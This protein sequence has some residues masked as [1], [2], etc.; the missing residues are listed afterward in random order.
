M[1]TSQPSVTRNKHISFS[2]QLVGTRCIE[3]G[4]GV[5]H[6]CYFKG[7]SCRKVGLDTTRD[8]IRRWALGG[9]NHVYTYRAGQLGDSGDRQF[10]FFT[11]C[12]NEVAE[13]V[14]NDNDIGHITVAFFGIELAGDEFGIVLFDIAHS[15][16]LQQF[17]SI[18]HFYTD[19][20]ECLYYFVRIGDNGFFAIGKF[21]QEMAFDDTVNTEFDFFGVYHHE[22]QLRR[23]LFIK[24]RCDDGIQTY[25]FSLSG[26]TGNE[27]VGHFAQIDH[28]NLIG[29]GFTQ[30]QRQVVIAFLKLA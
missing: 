22:L 30:C 21:R 19:R 11:G 28:E 1:Y 10:H 24:E 14:D 12:H 20:I 2:Y 8:D 6:R 13:L 26:R 9:D 16:H 27:Y 3:N 15:G 4:S 25:R 5:D 17:I 29:N 23:V 7:D 18:V